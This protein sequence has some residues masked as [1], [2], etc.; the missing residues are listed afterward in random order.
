MLA[1]TPHENLTDARDRPQ[2]LFVSY[3][4]SRSWTSL[5]ERSEYEPD[6]NWIDEIGLTDF[7]DKAASG[8]AG[9]IA[10]PRWFYKHGNV[11]TELGKAMFQETR[12]LV[13]LA[14][15]ELSSSF[16]FFSSPGSTASTH[17]DTLHNYYLQLHGRKRWRIF[18]PQA[19]LDN[20][21]THA[22]H[23]PRHT[24]SQ[25][26][27]D[28]V[29]RSHDPA[30][31]QQFPGLAGLQG[32]EVEMAEGDLLYVPPYFSH[33]VTALDTS[34]SMYAWGEI[35]EEA[36]L[37][38]IESTG[39]PILHNWD[40]DAAIHGILAYAFHLATEVAGLSISEV[41]EQWRRRYAHTKRHQEHAFETAGV[42]SNRILQA[43]SHAS[44]STP[45]DN[46]LAA[47][48]S[49]VSEVVDRVE[50]ASPSGVKAIQT[51]LV[52]DHVERVVAAT[53]GP[54]A[55]AVFFRTCVLEK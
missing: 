36:D 51:I 26:I 55:T 1:G 14:N 20:L 15:S 45:V 22:E 8:P 28:I 35:T 16:F 17:C 39:L 3:D 52:L 31:L 34:I 54:F 23:H 29:S 40:M 11:Q 49:R 30:V 42:N 38:S 21:Y 50:A 4:S 37:K 43:C 12:P 33:H 19:I 44:T 6:H 10:E 32:W 53:F 46:G 18:P 5:T 2:P 24:V 13:D 25:V 47:Y 48:I 41:T 9:V 7:F 27:G